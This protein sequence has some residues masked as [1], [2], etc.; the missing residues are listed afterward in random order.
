MDRFVE[1]S[2]APTLGGL[3]MTRVLC[4]IR[5]HAS[6][7]AHLLMARGI[8]AAIEVELRAFQYEARLLCYVLQ[9]FQT[10]WKQH[11]ICFIDRSHWAWRQHIAI[12][13]RHG[14]DFLTLL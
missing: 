14:N 3:A 11:H 6:I 5:H 4:D 10:I 1:Q 9:C 8:K 13:V 12:I 7:E 2:L